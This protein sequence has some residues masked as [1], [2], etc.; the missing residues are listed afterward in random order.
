MIA[1]TDEPASIHEALQDPKWVAAMDVEYKALMQNKTWRF[2]TP[3][4]GK[5]IIDYK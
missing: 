3:P 4:Q 2:V 1:T 5:N